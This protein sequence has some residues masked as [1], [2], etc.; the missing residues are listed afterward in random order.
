MTLADRFGSVT[1]SHRIAIDQIK[2]SKLC[3]RTH[4]NVL[5]LGVGDGAF[6]SKLNAHLPLA[7]F[8]GIDV[9]GDMLKRAQAL[10]PMKTIE[11]SATEVEH[12]LPPHSQ[13]LVLAHFI[14]AYIPIHTL[15][16][17]ANMLTRATGYFSIITTTYDSFPIAQQ[18]LADFIAQGSLLSSVVGQYY[19]SIVKST[20]VV[21]NQAELLQT[22][23]DH[24]FEILEHYRL[25]IPIVLNNIEDLALFGMEGTWFLNSLSI[26][27]LPKHFLLERLKRLFSKIFTFP[28]QD[29]HVIDVILARK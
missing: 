13:D 14:N 11:A 21:A 16:N 23:K 25:N 4:Y 26:R 7:E 27:M 28:Y 22:F 12:Y 29:T 9:C 19:K 5:D 6:L 18:Y 17:T 15:F 2:R 10:L 24:D 1:D 8:T 3:Q 20:T